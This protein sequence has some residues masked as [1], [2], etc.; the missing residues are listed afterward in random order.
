MDDHHVPAS[1]ET[2]YAVFD[3]FSKVI[4]IMRTYNVPP[5]GIRWEE[6]E[7]KNAL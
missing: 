1:R 3:N 2:L 4:K 5:Y 7:E 6:R